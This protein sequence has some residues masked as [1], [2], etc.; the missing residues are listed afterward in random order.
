M[1]KGLLKFGMS[2]AFPNI[3][4]NK[5]I[6]ISPVTTRITLSSILKEYSNNTI[7]KIDEVKAYGNVKLEMLN[8]DEYY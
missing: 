2:L 4:Y 5:K 7:N 6:Y 1:D 3:K 8:E